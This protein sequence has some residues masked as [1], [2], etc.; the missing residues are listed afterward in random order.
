MDQTELF[1]TF[2]STVQHCENS[3]RVLYE[4]NDFT[5][6]C[7]YRVFKMSGSTKPISQTIH[8]L[9][10]VDMGDIIEYVHKKTPLCSD[11]FSEVQMTIR[12]DSKRRLLEF[13]QTPI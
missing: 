11:N 7:D 12:E 6:Y 8:L 2:S 1:K 4:I 10:H 5:G 9:T 3:Y 13:L